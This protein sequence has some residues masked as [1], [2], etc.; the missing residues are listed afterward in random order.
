MKDKDIR[1]LIDA[2]T[3]PSEKG[4][5]AVSKVSAEEVRKIVMAKVK[6]EKKEGFSEA[7]NIEYAQPL[8]VSVNKKEKRRF[9]I[10]IAA[11]SAA[12]CVGI[13]G[14]WAYF[15]RAGIGSERLSPEDGEENPITDT[16]EANEP[17]AYTVTLLDGTRYTYDIDTQTET[18]VSSG[19]TEV[20]KLEGEK[21]Y[22]T[23][24]GEFIDVAEASGDKAYYVYGYY[25]EATGGEHRVFVNNTNEPFYCAYFE[26]YQMEGFKWRARGR[27]CY[28]QNGGAKQW[29]TEALGDI[30]LTLCESLNDGGNTV[31]LSG[32]VLMDSTTVPIFLNEFDP[33]DSISSKD[34]EFTL[35]DG[36]LV[37][38]DADGE[39]SADRIMYNTLFAM[40]GDR[41]FFIGNGEHM[42]ITDRIS[43]DS[44]FIYP[45]T[46]Q[47]RQ[48]THYIAA[49]GDPTSFGYTEVYPIF[50]DPDSAAAKWAASA[51]GL[52]SADSD[53]LMNKVVNRLREEYGINLLRRE[54]CEGE[55]MDLTDFSG[56]GGRAYSVDLIDVSTVKYPGDGMEVITREPIEILEIQDGCLWIK[57]KGWD[58]VNVTEEAQGKEYYIAEL[59]INGKPHIFIVN[60][61]IDPDECGYIDIFS[62]NGEDT[63]KFGV[64]RNIENPGFYMASQAKRYMNWLYEAFE[65]LGFT[66]VES[67]EDACNPT[68]V[69]IQ[70]HDLPYRVPVSDS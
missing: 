39:I 69:Y 65:E 32:D 66:M 19:F 33:L 40:E 52:G 26:L 63:G 16:A 36:T 51:V 55:P 59:G 18:L 38:I 34:E 67:S 1:R 61:T 57:N 17:D 60:N 9:G 68:E 22:F 11:G 2:C 21:L 49:T 14:I 8:Y 30:G 31:D 37:G 10:R 45:Y 41:V 53:R 6:G 23:G 20:L 47:K 46:H 50:D 43:V 5:S 42:D 28:E 70:S 54:F 64:G 27:N 62:V 12:A 3:A 58:D 29:V 24:N 15:A 13:V 35:M 48:K 25:N 7:E 4:D 44:V 56:K